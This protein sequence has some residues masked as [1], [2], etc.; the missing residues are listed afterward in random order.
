[1]IGIRAGDG[2][3]LSLWCRR[4]HLRCRCWSLPG[5]CSNSEKD[6][7]TGGEDDEEEAVE[8]EDEGYDN[9][10]DKREESWDK[11]ERLLPAS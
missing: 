10:H 4:C 11:N 3:C 6:P 8:R 9:I 5:C 7:E 1:M 2:T